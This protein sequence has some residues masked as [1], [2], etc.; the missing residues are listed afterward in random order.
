[1]KKTVSALLVCVLLIGSLLT[2]ASCGKSL[3]GVYKEALTS[4]IS[5]EFGAFGKVTKTV[6]NFI[7]EDTV[8][9]GKYEFNDDGSKITLTFDDEAKTYDFSSGEEDGVEYIKLD[10]W[11]YNKA[12]K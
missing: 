12:D 2:L 6:D 3:S 11:K 8:T 1:M 4:N 5:Y 9:E 10:G 7:G